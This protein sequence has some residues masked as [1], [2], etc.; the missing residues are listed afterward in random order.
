MSEE[1]DIIGWDIALEH[2]AFY[3]H[4]VSSEVVIAHVDFYVTEDEEE[5]YQCWWDDNL[6]ETV[7]DYVTYTD[8]WVDG[9]LVFE[10]ESALDLESYF[11]TGFDAVIDE[12]NDLIAELNT[13]YS[14]Y[15]VEMDPIDY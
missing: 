11:D 14:D 2:M 1:I 13:L 10:D 4:Y 9:R 5:D 7:C 12:L 15:G 6:G 8:Y 3:A